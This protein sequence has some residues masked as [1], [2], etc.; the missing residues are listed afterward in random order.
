MSWFCVLLFEKGTQMTQIQLIF[1]DALLT[2]AISCNYLMFNNLK[3]YQ[4]TNLNT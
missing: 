3:T 4:P 1:T 2:D